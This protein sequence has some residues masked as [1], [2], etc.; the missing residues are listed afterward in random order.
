MIWPV[1]H[2][3]VYHHI[4]KAETIHF[5]YTRTRA[6][7]NM[8]MYLSK[9]TH[10]GRENGRGQSSDGV[11][12]IKYNT[13][14]HTKSHRISG[15]SY[16]N[17]NATASKACFSLRSH[18]APRRYAICNCSRLCLFIESSEIR[19]ECKFGRELRACPDIIL[20]HPRVPT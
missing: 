7:I 2:E 4:R 20:V 8:C 14:T 5:T 11:F 9:S 10:S 6:Y 12:P 19:S 1:Q 16:K 13:H 17:A 15:R 18:L 3:V